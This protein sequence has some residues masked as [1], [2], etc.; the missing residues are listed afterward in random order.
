MTAAAPAAAPTPP[1]TGLRRISQTQWIVIAMVVGVAIGYLFPDR[2]DGVGGFE[3]SDLQ[4][5]SNVF[6][7]MIKSLIVPLLF[8]TLVVGIAGHGDDMKRV[9]KLAFR[10]ILYFEVITTLALVVGLLA[11]N[12]VKPGRGVNISTASSE[13]GAELAKTHTTFAGVV[14]HTV[15][16]SFSTR[17]RRTRSSRSSSSPSSSP[18]R[19]PRCRGRPRRSCSRSARA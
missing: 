4:V 1:R 8:G 17:R 2:P 6:L 9:G 12:I 15:P 18:S 14:E 19:C 7:R 16:Q 5:L 3:A 10:S 13:T 11:V